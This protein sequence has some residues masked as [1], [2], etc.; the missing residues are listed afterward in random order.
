[1]VDPVV[2]GNDACVSEDAVPRS[3]RVAVVACVALMSTLVVWFTG[4]GASSSP[5]ITTGVFLLIVLGLVLVVRLGRE[6]ASAH[7]ADRKEE[8]PGTSRGPRPLRDIP[9]AQRQRLLVV[10]GCAVLMFLLVAPLAVLGLLR[11]LPLTEVAPRLLVLALP[12][13]GVVFVWRQ[14]RYPTASTLSVEQDHPGPAVD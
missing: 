8:T 4:S 10:L 1:V 7:G 12:I 2:R 11:G 3:R 14:V 5:G 9:R 13:L 6:Q